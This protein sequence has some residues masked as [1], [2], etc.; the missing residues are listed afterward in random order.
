MSPMM[1]LIESNINGL[2]TQAQRPGP[3]DAWIATGAR[4]P[5]SLQRMVRRQ[6]HIQ[7]SV[8]VS[9]TSGS[10][11]SEREQTTVATQPADAALWK[12]ILPPD[13]REMKRLRI[14][15]KRRERISRV[16]VV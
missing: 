2:T 10:P 8:T 7:D 14:A 13:A 15:G 4:W 1:L 6:Y 5:G 11:K 9:S 12:M 3:R 16:E